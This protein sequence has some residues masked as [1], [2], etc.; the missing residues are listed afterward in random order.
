MTKPLVYGIE[1]YDRVDTSLASSFGDQICLFTP[2]TKPSIWDKTFVTQVLERLGYLR[3]NPTIDYLLIAGHM[4][5]LCLALDA[6]ASR[7][8]DRQLKLL[9]WDAE[10]HHYACIQR[11][12]YESSH[13]RTVPSR[14][15]TPR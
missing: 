1:P 5:T 4:P 15:P 2:E 14:E 13:K 11:E 9:F 7:Y 10:N 12:P 3:F 6:I 8:A